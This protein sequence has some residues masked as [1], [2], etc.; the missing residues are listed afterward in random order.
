MTRGTFANIRLK[1]RLIPGVEGGVTIHL[2]GSNEHHD[3]AE[4]AEGVPSL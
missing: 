2:P 1:N 4:I 3:A